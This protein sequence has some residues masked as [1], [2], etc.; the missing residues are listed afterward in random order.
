[1]GSNMGVVRSRSAFPYRNTLSR[2][3]VKCVQH[4]GSQLLLSGKLSVVISRNLDAK[5]RQN[6]K[7]TGEEGT[8]VA[9]LE[10]RPRLLWETLCRCQSRLITGT[11]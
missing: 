3:E 4:A 11:I 2:D 10:R 5:R 8:I 9:T 7:G 6:S 1:M